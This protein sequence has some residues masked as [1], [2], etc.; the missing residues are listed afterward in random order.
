MR[1]NKLYFYKLQAENLYF[2]HLNREIHWKTKNSAYKYICV[3]YSILGI[4]CKNHF[5]LNENG[6]G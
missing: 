2:M 5:N 4:W 3:A 1:D 6:N